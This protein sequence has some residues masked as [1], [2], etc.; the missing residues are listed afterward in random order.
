MHL[1]WPVEED[2]DYL[3]G[4]TE[5]LRLSPSFGDPSALFEELEGG[6]RRHCL[7][8]IQVTNAGRSVEIA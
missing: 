7:A 2:L 1:T 3:L 6:D 5:G 8:A 4:E